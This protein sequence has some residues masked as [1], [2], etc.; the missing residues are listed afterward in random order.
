[1]MLK[2]RINCQMCI[3][4]TSARQNRKISFVKPTI[5]KYFLGIQE[6][7]TTWQKR[8]KPCLEEL[9]RKLLA[10]LCVPVCEQ[11]KAH[12]LFSLQRVQGRRA[13]T[14]RANGNP[15]SVLARS[16]PAP[17]HLPVSLGMSVYLGHHLWRGDNNTSCLHV[18]LGCKCLPIKTVSY[19]VC[20]QYVVHGLNLLYRFWSLILIIIE[21]MI[22][23]VIIQYSS[24]SNQAA[25][26]LFLS[27]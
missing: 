14:V 18:C 16:R 24:S 8:A 1:M 3:K 12:Q 21:V 4:T 11:R 22:N 6:P 23:T 15:A 19:Y 17:S 7:C 27:E 5:Y 26:A 13:V 20:Q 2:Q 9:G 10:M 25:L